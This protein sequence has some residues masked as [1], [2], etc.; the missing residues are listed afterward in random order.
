MARRRK[1]KNRDQPLDA[2]AVA[3]GRLDVRPGQLFDL[4]HE[5]NPTGRDLPRAETTRRYQLKN[6]L[7]SPLV[8]RFGDEHLIVRPGD[9]GTV[10]LDHRSG[11]RDACHAVVDELEPD[12]RSWVR[13]RLDL[14]ASPAVEDDA[15]TTIDGR[16]TATG[17]PSVEALVGRARRAVQEYD[18]EAAERDLTQAFAAS[19]GATAAALPL[20]ELWVE[21]LGLDRQALELE[22]RLDADARVHPAV[23]THLA[24]AAA[25]AGEA[26]R[27]RE[28]VKGIDSQGAA[29][30]H[31][32]LADAAARAGDRQAAVRHLE[33][34]RRRDPAHPDLPRLADAVAHL[35]AE[36]F[37][38]LED[39]LGERYRQ[40][41]AAATAEAARRL[42]DRW[43]ES[44]LARRI[45]HEAA[46]TR[47]RS[48]IDEHVELG[49]R[50]WAEERF[51]D[52]VLHFRKALDLG[53][54]RAG[55]A[56]RVE[57]ARRRERERETRERVAAV[58]A[59]FDDDPAAA[60]LAY[61]ALPPP[62]R[63][64]VRRRVD[65]P[66]LAWLEVGVDVPVD[67]RARDVEVCDLEG[68]SQHA[69]GQGGEGEL[70]DEAALFLDPQRSHEVK[71][72]PFIVQRECVAAV[73]G[74][75]LAPLASALLVADVPA[76]IGVLVAGAG[77]AEREPPDAE[78]GLRH[79][80]DG[81]H[82]ERLQRY[83]LAEEENVE[84]QVVTGG[85][86]AALVERLET[87]GRGAAGWPCR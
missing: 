77:E 37:R 31:V 85:E 67:R 52:V 8:R 72:Q 59:R 86:V 65:R 54:E 30:V 48:E 21:S 71:A 78:A 19:G 44:K 36:D 24:L 68:A 38:P 7:R 42:L 74:G 26:A 75:D 79:A 33:K 63:E 50:A 11:S 83:R 66:A 57:E 45:V 58:V 4:I 53:S 82:G 87:N 22:P 27:A 3:D 39:A 34:A 23:R 69:E 5:V 10:S 32:A 1:H 18:Y 12:A 84:L 64:D 62:L 80:L 20:L 13:L 9:D 46:E 41:G 14:A 29:E 6:R 47:R 55:L 70:V 76:S 60:L 61:L 43:P 81:E 51:A 2:E 40:E 35:Q 16:A 15:G 49:E 56:E 17:E 28:L 25:R 73:D